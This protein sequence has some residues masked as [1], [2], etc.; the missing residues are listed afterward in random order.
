MRRLTVAV[1]RALAA[2]AAAAVLLAG[3]TAVTSTPAAEAP[4]PVRSVAPTPSPTPTRATADPEIPRI[5]ATVPPIAPAPAP[6]VRLAVDWAG[7]DVPVEAKGVDDRGEMDL[8]AD[9]RI[10]GWYRFSAAPSDRSGTTVLGAHVDAVGYGIGPFS[11]LVDVPTGTRI[12]LTAADGSTKV[13]V[14]DSV[15]MITKTA[16]P[17]TSIFDQTGRRRLVLVTCGGEFN[18]ST[19][20]YLSNLVVT[21]RPA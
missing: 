9:P 5:V 16:V 2:S 3:C 11:H 7:I 15:R 19:H 20:H 4:A 8:P 6:P 21:A 1:A 14:V 13:F 10:A 17:W 12:T 18:Y